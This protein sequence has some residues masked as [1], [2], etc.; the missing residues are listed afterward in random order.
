M[1]FTATNT[2]TSLYTLIK[3]V[4]PDLTKLSWSMYI[5]NTW[6]NDLLFDTKNTNVNTEWVVLKA[7]NENVYDFSDL[8]KIFIQTNTWTTTINY[9]FV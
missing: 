9:I 3:S 5:Q 8:S 2:V 6:S 7:W 4:E 1:R